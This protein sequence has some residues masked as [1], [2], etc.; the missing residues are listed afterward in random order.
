MQLYF[1]SSNQGKIREVNDFFQSIKKKPN[2]EICGVNDL[3]ESIQKKFNPI[4]SGS[5]FQANSEIKAACLSELIDKPV[6]A[7]DTGLVVDALGGRPGVHSAR[8]ADTD[9][10]R[11][12]KLLG[13]LSSVPAEN[14]KAAFVTALSYIPHKGDMITFFG[15]VHG[16]IALQPSGK[17]GFGYDPVFIPDGHSKTF[18]EL[19]LEEKRNLSHRG[20]ALRAF[21]DY[22]TKTLSE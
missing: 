21:C 19:S 15:R 6:F 5:T 12:S 7:E 13:E 1:A 18:A 8:Y 14:R 10:E 17:E 22:L 4:E 2:F 3:P 11:I 9:E 16:M 20:R